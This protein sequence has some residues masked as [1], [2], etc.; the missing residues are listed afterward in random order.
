[1]HV[2]GE[3]KCFATSSVASTPSGVF[4]DPYGSIHQK[5]AADVLGG[6]QIR[7]VAV[8]ILRHDLNPASRTPRHLFPE[9]YVP[10]TAS[11]HQAEALIEEDI[12]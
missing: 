2:A 6:V 9:H 7:L 10:R 4:F 1:V 12:L 5:L 3:L 8:A 11:P